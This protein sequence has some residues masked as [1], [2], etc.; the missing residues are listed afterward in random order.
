MV[1]LAS[2]VAIC[3]LMA[4][5]TACK[6]ADNETDSVP[7]SR[8]GLTGP[9]GPVPRSCDGVVVDPSDNIQ[10]VIDAHPAG[11]TY[12]FS[13]GMYR[14]E[15]P[16]RPKEGDALIGRQGA[17]VSGARVLT[18]WQQ[19]G[20]TWSTTG[21]LPTVPGNHGECLKSVLTC[22]YAEDV[23]LD[24]HR[25]TRVE[26]PDAVT[27][28]TVHADYRANTITIGDDP[29]PHLVEQAVASSLVRATADDVTV[30]NLVLEQA[31]N[32]AQVAAV[33]SRQATPRESGSGWRI[34]NNEVRGNHGAGL[35]LAGRAVVT[36]NFVHHQGQLGFGAWGTGSVV[37]SNEI[38]FNGVAGYSPDWEAGG[39][40]IWH[41]DSYTVTHNDVHDNLGP[42]LWTDGGNIRTEYSANKITG[43]WGAGIQHEISYDATIRDNVISANGSRHKG[44]SWEAGIQIQSSGGTGLIEVAGN[45]VSGNANGI[46]LIES[47]HRTT[48]EPAPYGPHVVRNILVHDNRVTMS[49]GQ[50]TGAVQDIGDTAV[51]T[52]RNNR[53]EANTYYLPSLPEPHFFWNDT[54]LTWARWRALGNDVNGRAVRTTR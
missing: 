13:P 39:G 23:F 47:G 27:P 52:G 46:A 25:L 5:P 20:N 4:L 53:F 30:A 34:H 51:F 44:W 15:Q 31:A 16:L 3:M 50:S 32:E 49:T 28:G 26:S 2:A 40:K 41:T 8:A 37:N 36:A 42:G 6:G 43:N 1:N 33:E 24:K 38:S 29:R 45:V 22:A 18:G 9:V 19:H 12:C 11:T 54:E 10:S 21:F 7:P 17:V 35:G 14:L 48:E